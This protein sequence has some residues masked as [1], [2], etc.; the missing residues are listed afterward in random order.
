MAV[1]ILESHAQA[2]V[3]IVDDS[4]L[5]SELARR[6]LEPAHKV[7]AALDL[8]EGLA[9][10]ADDFLTKPYNAAEL[11][12]MGMLPAVPVVVEPQVAS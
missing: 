8:V 10:G 5:E 11:D 3:W 2:H 12:E 7:P 6:A 1:D 4:P 9:A